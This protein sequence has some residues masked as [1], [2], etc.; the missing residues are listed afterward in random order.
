MNNTTRRPARRT[1]RGV[2]LVEVMIAATISLWMF[3]LLMSVTRFQAIVF[4]NGMT[5]STSQVNGQLA[6]NRIASTLR[7][8][9]SVLPTSTSTRIDLQLPA[10]DGS[11]NLLV[12]VT[13]GQRI[14]F[15]LSNSTGR[16][17][18]TGSILWRSVDGTADAGWSLQGQKG[19]VV[20][21][22]GGLQFTY[23]PSVDPE[24]V[25]VSIVATNTY[26]TDTGS[27]AS[28]QEFMLRNHG[29]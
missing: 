22:S 21:S 18:Q 13:D 1:R 24:T 23:I 5:D 12:P 19:R 17:D 11:G 8:A 27:F 16:T 9:R 20:L 7:T 3:S 10:Y 26:G 28:S 29:L 25:I 6:L 14:S 4:Q 15:Y 2:S